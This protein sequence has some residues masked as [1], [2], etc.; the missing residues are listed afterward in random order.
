MTSAKLVK[1]SSP[2]KKTTNGTITLDEIVDAACAWAEGSQQNPTPPALDALARALLQKG[3]PELAMRLPDAIAKHYLHPGIERSIQALIFARIAASGHDDA[4]SRATA[5]IEAVE[6]DWN[7]A[8][9]TGSPPV[10]I[11][12]LIAARVI[13]TTAADRSISEIE[14]LVFRAIQHGTD[15]LDRSFETLLEL[16]HLDHATDWFLR[17]A[18]ASPR[19]SRATKL[20]GALMKELVASGQPDRALAVHAHCADHLKHSPVFFAAEEIG[21]LD[22]PTIESFFAVANSAHEALARGLLAAQRTEEAVAFYESHTSSVLSHLGFALLANDEAAIARALAAPTPDGK[23]DVKARYLFKAGRID[24]DEA[25]DT[26]LSAHPEHTTSLVDGLV[27]LLSELATRGDRDD[28]DRVISE[29]DRAWAT[30]S[31]SSFDEGVHTTCRTG[32]LA[33]RAAA[34]TALEDTKAA[35]S[36]LKEAAA[37]AAKGNTKSRKNSAFRDLVKA[38]LRMDRPLDAYRAAKKISKN[39]RNLLVTD[40]VRGFLPEDPAGAFRAL[41]LTDFPPGRLPVLPEIVA[42][43]DS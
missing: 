25:L 11:D 43:V 4:L 3:A 17:H 23:A 34:Y 28:I 38:A 10:D 20:I 2:K 13:L 37:A 39:D 12:N 6:A 22:M 36:A 35:N 40:V 9:E 1:L 5:L 19:P 14:P 42:A 8:M 18:E 32:E 31:L 24:L 7:L 16:G 33:A 26:T 29:I 21:R 27:G 30:R 15:S 41:G